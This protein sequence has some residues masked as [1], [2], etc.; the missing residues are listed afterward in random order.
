MTSTGMPAF[1]HILQPE[2]SRYGAAAA[3]PPK[4]PVTTELPH[5]T[6]L[7]QVS[8][9]MNSAIPSTAS[10]EV[11]RA[12]WQTIVKLASLLDLT[13]GEKK[14]ILDLPSVLQSAEETTYNP[15]LRAIVIHDEECA[16]GDYAALAADFIR[17]ELLPFSEDLVADP[18]YIRACKSVK[19]LSFV[20]R[21][22]KG[23]YEAAKAQKARALEDFQ[24]KYGRSKMFFESLAIGLLEQAGH[25][26]TKEG[27]IFDSSLKTVLAQERARGEKDYNHEISFSP[28]LLDKVEE[29]I[30]DAGINVDVCR[31]LAEEGEPFE[32]EHHPLQKG[33]DELTSLPAQPVWLPRLVSLVNASLDAL[34]NS[35][36]NPGKERAA[37]LK[38]E[39]K[40]KELEDFYAG[41]EREVTQWPKE[42][43]LIE[44][45][46][47]RLAPGLFAARARQDLLKA[48]RSG[49][50]TE[51][52]RMPTAVMDAE[53]IVGK[54]LKSAQFVLNQEYKRGRKT[55]AAAAR[56][57][58]SVETPETGSGS[59]V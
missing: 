31:H 50:V 48:D 44:S 7:D 12:V 11:C 43:K 36:S 54:P 23:P 35:G 10:P 2:E 22:F 27:N 39:K 24:T 5:T 3:V 58:H 1:P 25:I 53:Y 47:R 55:A 26:D 57:S 40:I 29:I 8:V 13:E 33:M 9:S 41:L 37:F 28:E 42:S 19:N 49:A 21:L 51:V 18:E 52:Y 32:V 17:N 15:S 34:R 46:N 30:R 38:A 45:L 14:K 16:P 20:K 6:S 56:N 4:E 59:A